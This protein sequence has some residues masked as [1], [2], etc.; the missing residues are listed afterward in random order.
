M[1]TYIVLYNMTDQG[2]KNIETLPERVRQ[3]RSAA[4]RYGIKVQ[5]WYLTEGP[6]DVVTI[7]DAPD[8][9]TLAAGV[10]A[11]A[12]NGNFKSQ[13]MRAFSESEMDQIVQKLT[14]AS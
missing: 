12:R 3:A 8:E 10:L 1:S 6:Y 4:E 11:I 9:M 7:V 14:S 13:T 2:A 5:G